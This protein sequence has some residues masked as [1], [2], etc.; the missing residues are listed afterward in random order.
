MENIIFEKYMHDFD[1]IGL[2][3]FVESTYVNIKQYCYV[4]RFQLEEASDKLMEFIN[5]PRKCYIE[6]GNKTGDCTPAFSME[7]EQSD[8][9]GH[10]RI[11]L[12]LEVDDN[13]E[14]KHRCQLYIYSNMGEIEQFGEKI[15]DLVTSDIYTKI[16]LY[17]N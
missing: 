11:E 5:N 1:L 6:F 7:I 4:D 2:N 9:L 3:V 8:S 14:R 15:K 16:S 10:V 12:D 13:T 17:N